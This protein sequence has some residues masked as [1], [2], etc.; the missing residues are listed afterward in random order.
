MK[1][2]I[3]VAKFLLLTHIY[4]PAIDGGSRVIAKMGEFLQSNNHQVSIITTDCQSTDDFSSPRHSQIKIEGGNILRLPV[5]TLFH[6]PFKFLGRFFPN[7][8]TLSKGPIFSPYSSFSFLV[9]VLRFHP[10]YI[11][12][13]PLPTTMVLYANFLKNFINII[14]KINNFPS[15]SQRRGLRGGFCKLIINASFHPT[16]SDFQTPILL[17]TLKSADYIWTLTDFETNYL[18]KKLN[19][20][21]SK[22]ILLG[23]GIDKSFIRIEDCSL[24]IEDSFNL[25]FIGSFSAHK[26]IPTLIKAFSLLPPSYTLTLAGQKTLYF[27]VIQKQ[28]DSL[29]LSIKKRIKIIT[30]FPD[31]DLSKLIDN[32]SILI[33]P[34]TQESF[35]LV[36]LEALA[37][38]KPVIAAD[39]PASM[40]I[41][42]KTKGGLIFKQNDPEDLASKIIK[43]PSLITS[44]LLHFSSSYLSNHYTW[45][46]IGEKLCKKL[47]IY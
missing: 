12:A 9:S 39:I 20:P 34:S 28:I 45:D 2:T 5:I 10:D 14:Y 16:D 42:K 29:P 13:G 22:L 41:V 19:I 30:S 17:N 6:R 44:N 23:N 38:G 46:K 8:K 33:S 18:N 43:L 7:F 36:L 25:L 21:K 24:K 26:N 3:S 11:L 15:F 27:P 40:E 4:P 35:G 31:S 37:R 47:D 32:C 1:Y